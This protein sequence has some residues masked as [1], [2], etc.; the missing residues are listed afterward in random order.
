MHMAG[1]QSEVFRAVAEA[2]KIYRRGG[3]IVVAGCA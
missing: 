2:I 1:P 3:M